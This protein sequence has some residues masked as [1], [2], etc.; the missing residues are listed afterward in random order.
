MA[1]VKQKIEA[2][3]MSKVINGH[4]QSPES[5]PGAAAHR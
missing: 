4:T 2:T 1:N 3:V 5:E